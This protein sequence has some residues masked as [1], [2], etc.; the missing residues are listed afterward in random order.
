MESEK[1]REQERLRKKDK[2]Q[3]ERQIDD[4]PKTTNSQTAQGG[5]R[6]STTGTT[7]IPCWVEGGGLRSPQCS[8]DP[9]GNAA[10]QREHR[11]SFTTTTYRR[12]A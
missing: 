3:I 7:W 11:G 12:L 4:S 10:V 9:H 6:M 2:E 8:R 5:G 1:E